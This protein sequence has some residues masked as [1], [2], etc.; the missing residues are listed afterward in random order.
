MTRMYREF[1]SYF[2]ELRIQKSVYCGVFSFQ[3]IGSGGLVAVTDRA[4]LILHKHHITNIK[5]LLISQ[6]LHSSYTF[7]STF[8]YTIIFFYNS[9]SN[10]NAKSRKVAGSRP[11]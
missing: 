9:D 7:S 5:D 6:I 4:T 2:T 3:R 8:T 1:C 10:N 11:D